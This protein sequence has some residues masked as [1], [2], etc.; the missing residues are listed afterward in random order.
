MPQSAGHKAETINTRL[1]SATVCTGSSTITSYLQRIPLFARPFMQL[2]QSEVH[3]MS[4]RV[5]R[6]FSKLALAS[7]A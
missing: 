6:H 2:S 1:C 4:S 5:V 3:A 7:S